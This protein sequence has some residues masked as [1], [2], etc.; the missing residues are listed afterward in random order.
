M[1]LYRPF[2]FSLLATVASI[3]SPS[4][5]AWTCVS[6]CSVVNNVIEIKVATPGSNDYT[7]ITGALAHLKSLTAP[8]GVTKKLTF[9]TSST[10]LVYKPTLTVSALGGI[11]L[12]DLVGHQT[13][14]V[15]EGNGAEIQ[16]SSNEIIPKTKPK[17]TGLSFFR[18]DNSYNV[19]INGFKIGYQ[20]SSIVQGTVVPGSIDTVNSTFRVMTD[21]ITDA[22]GA[23]PYKGLMVPAAGSATLTKWANAA[24]YAPGAGGTWTFVNGEFYIQNVRD[25]NPTYTGNNRIYQIDVS[26]AFPSHVKDGYK[27]GFRRYGATAEVPLFYLEKSKNIVYSNLEVYNTIKMAFAG[28]NNVGTITHYNVKVIPKP[29]SGYIASASSDSFHYNTNR[30]AVIIDSCVVD[31]NFDDGVNLGNSFS[32]ASKLFAKT[33]T[34]FHSYDLTYGRAVGNNFVYSS[35]GFKPGDI[36]G[37]LT[38]GTTNTNDSNRRPMVIGFSK[39]TASNFVPHEATTER[40]RLVTHEA[41]A[42]STLPIVT[43]DHSS[44]NIYSGPSTNKVATIDLSNSTPAEPNSHT[45]NRMSNLSL[46]TPNSVVINSVFRNK[47]RNGVIAR[48]Y[49]IAVIGNTFSNLAGSAIDGGTGWSFEEGSWPYLSDYSG[50]IVNNVKYHGVVFN[51]NAEGCYNA[52]PCN[53]TSPTVRVGRAPGGNYSYVT[54]NQLTGVNIGILSVNSGEIYEGQNVISGA[55]SNYGVAAV[56]TSFVPYPN[57]SNHILETHTNA[58]G[59]SLPVTHRPIFKVTI[60]GVTKHYYVT[61]RSVCQLTAGLLA[62]N[63]GPSAG[64]M[65]SEVP[66]NIVNQT[67]MINPTATHL[68]ALPPGRINQG[69]CLA[70]ETIFQDGAGGAYRRERTTELGVTSS[71]TCKYGST[72]RFSASTGLPAS[73]INSLVNLGVPTG[74]VTNCRL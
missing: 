8:A 27:I 62:S 44:M 58:T 28:H 41:L 72:Q 61:N 9:P 74:T 52:A 19:T 65:T 14:M 24:T 33:A 66:V 15:I 25:M 59:T 50:N 45:M 36:L 46:A 16:L 40:L 54:N 26:G 38:Y 42:G 68:T 60:N 21:A 13:P 53:T 17:M 20:T 23:Y 3:A 1:K 49:R 43:L 57:L 31:G 37:H 71:K 18:G 12:F 2:L 39:V 56:N 51:I 5:S 10:Q 30:G 69:T 63:W 48:G 70:N 32:V 73:M 4:A 47:L 64:S 34:S 55:V 67:L 7:E 22:T 29:G 11:P 6:S 35:A